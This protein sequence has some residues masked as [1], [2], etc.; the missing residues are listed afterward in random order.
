MKQWT[1]FGAGSALA[2]LLGSTAVQAD[3]TA[4][5]VW[6]GWVD[7]YTASGQ[8]VTSDAS[9]M[10]GDT[11]V[12]TNAVIASKRS[13]EGAFT[14]TLP[15]V[16]LRETGDGRVEITLPAEMPV[17][18]SGKDPEGKT[19][20]TDLMVKQ[21]DLLITASGAPED[22]TYDA[23]AASVGLVLSSAVSEGKE[24]PATVDLTMKD[25]TSQ[26]HMVRTG[27]FGLDSTF[28]AASADLKVA[29]T[30]SEAGNE[31]NFDLT[32]TVQN[33]AGTSKAQVVEG[34]DLNGNLAAALNAGTN[35][36]GTFTYGGGT[37]S[38]SFKSAK[39]GEGKVDYKDSA[40]KLHFAMSKDGLSY[41]GESGGAQMNLTVPNLP[42]NLEVSL[43][44]SIFDFAM[45]VAK[46]AAP[47][48]FKI[49]TKLVDLKVADAIWDMF[50]PTK[51]LPRDPATVV[52]DANGTATLDVDIFDP[53]T[54]QST[55]TPGKID[56]V[57][58][59]EVRLSVAGAELTGS[60]QATIDNTGETPKP[61]GAV[62]LKLVGGNGLMD[63]LVAMGLVPEDQAMGVRMMLGAFTVPSGDDVLTSKIEFKEDGSISANGQR[64]Q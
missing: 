56:Q 20:E 54:A 60:G 44:S 12:V 61:V 32:G 55:K 18:I 40:G 7:Y 4:E 33:L 27:G 34:A 30:S 16:R 59:N 53:A 35:M 48:P 14:V 38:A 5:Q 64:L 15:E 47:Q 58:L 57:S 1:A 2:L 39:D 8:V 24:L 45:P 37:Y 42:P 11:L 17:K 51:Q 9:A 25:I 10:E 49:V 26:S 63:K 3:V 46:G 31:G 50:D 28:S 6:Q 43:G 62:D 36:S 22:I 23:K 19:V 52:I 21:S 13:E 41:G 29:A